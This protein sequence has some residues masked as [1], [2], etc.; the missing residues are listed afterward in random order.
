MHIYINNVFF[1]CLLTFGEIYAYAH[2]PGLTPKRKN[3]RIH[4]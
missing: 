4:F 3:T 2:V 1:F